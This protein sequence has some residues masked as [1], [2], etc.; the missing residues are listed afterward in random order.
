MSDDRT[1]ALHPV[2]AEWRDRLQTARDD[3]QAQV[4]ELGLA[5]L[6]ALRATL[7]EELE[8]VA[9]ALPEP[10]P[11]EARGPM[12]TDA[13]AQYVQQALRYNALQ[14]RRQMVAHA[15]RRR[16]L[17]STAPAHN[18]SVPDETKRLAA[19]AWAVMGEGDADTPLAVYRAVAERAEADLHLTTVETWLRDENPHY[20]ADAGDGWATLRRAVLLA[21]A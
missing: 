8:A 19:L 11:L 2:R 5:D 1:R 3:A 17:G 9:D 18:V 15:L 16:A 13:Q 12:A 20:P 4:K 6:R 10:A 14:V 7:D 21:A